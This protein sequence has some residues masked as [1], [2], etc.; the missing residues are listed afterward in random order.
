LIDGLSAL[1]EKHTRSAEPSAL[2]Q[3]ELHSRLCLD[4]LA[5]ALG[6]KI[7]NALFDRNVLRHGVQ[8]PEV[9]ADGSVWLN[10]MGVEN[11]AQ[12][13]GL[14]CPLRLCHD[15]SQDAY[16]LGGGVA[17]GLLVAL[18]RRD[19]LRVRRGQSAV[20]LTP[21]GVSGL[22]AELGLDLR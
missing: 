3:A 9:T 11:P 6:C 22:R 17:N 4:H 15:W 19:W 20:L 16:H 1:A 8:G 10:R 21:K 7:T 2:P 14:R 5:G 12:H 18:C 13:D